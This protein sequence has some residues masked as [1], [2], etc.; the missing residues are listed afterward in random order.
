[1]LQ[2]SKVHQAAVFAGQMFFIGG[3]YWIY[4]ALTE[5]RLN[6]WKLSLAGIHWALAL[7]AR[8]SI[9][10]LILYSTA[11]AILY[12][13]LLYKPRARGMLIPIFSI[14]IPLLIAAVSLAWYN[15]AR[16][17]SI[18]E[19]GLRYTLTDINYTTATDVFSIKHIGNNFHNYFTYPLRVRAHF[20]YL[21]RIEYSNSN[22]RLG[23]LLFIAPFIL[24]AL[25]P[26]L[27]GVR[28]LLARKK[29]SSPFAVR[30]QPESWLL[31]TS[32]GSAIIGAVLILSFWTTQIR[33]TDDFMPSLLLFAIANVAM[34]YGAL[35]NEARGRKLFSF[36][37]VLFVCITAVASTL[38]AL[39]SDSLSF[40]V[41]LAD[42]ALRILN[43]K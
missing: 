25:L 23:G 12:I 4:A 5:N 20:P 8:I 39:K 36:V 32:A 7:G 35:E 30:I 19:F 41:N 22:E 27:S 15:W 18:F 14:G 1:M 40:W 29:L 21:I 10:P 26:I 34:V 37:T 2:E 42:T 31:V 11:T 16:F 13:F 28:M 33:Y 24:F 38:V 3:I 6:V 9:A 43:L 17:D